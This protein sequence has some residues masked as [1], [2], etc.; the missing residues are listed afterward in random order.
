MVYYIQ[1]QHKAVKTCSLYCV[2][3]YRSESLANQDI[4]YCPSADYPRGNNCGGH[5][6][7][8]NSVHVHK[9]IPGRTHD[10]AHFD[11]PQFT[12]PL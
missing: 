7:H 4:L 12:M 1:Y 11:D 6:L 8:V 5:K 3:T 2:H 9:L 10:D